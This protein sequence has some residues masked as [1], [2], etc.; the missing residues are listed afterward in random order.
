MFLL[1]RL[2]F[3]DEKWLLSTKKGTFERIYFIKRKG[4]NDGFKVSYLKTLAGKIA[5]LPYPERT[6]LIRFLF[7]YHFVNLQ[8]L[9]ETRKGNVYKV[10]SIIMRDVSF[11]SCI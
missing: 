3:D 4:I 8:K 1:G 2:F 6:C 10:L 9:Y 11:F 5:L 7:S